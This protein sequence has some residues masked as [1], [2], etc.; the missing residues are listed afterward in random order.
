MRRMNLL[1][2]LVLFIIGSPITRAETLYKWIDSQG[3]VSYHDHL[4][5]ADSEYRVETKNVN[6]GNKSKSDD[7]LA[8]AAEKFPV[9]LYSVPECGSCDLA[10]LY[11]QKRK[12]PF[13]ES[14]LNDNP[15]LQQTLKKKIGS[16]SVPTLTI[17]D[18]VMKG[19]VESV[20]EGQLDE[21]GY[22]K[23][24][25]PEK[26]TGENSEKD[27]TSTPNYPVTP[28]TRRPY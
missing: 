24:E 21:A 18:K 12:V 2:V 5:P 8:G 22:P 26:A 17:G 20:L 19:Y 27:K 25:V 14:N 15:E 7:T 10:R 9:V 11:L 3:R 13:T 16:V 4:P 1:L 23:V 6:G 28:S